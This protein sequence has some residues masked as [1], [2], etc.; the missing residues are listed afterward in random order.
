MR[1]KLLW[2]VVFMMSFLLVGGLLFAGGSKEKGTAAPKAENQFITIWWAQWAPADYLQKLSEDF[3]AKTGIKVI[4]EQT[5]WS[6]F[7]QKY[8]VAMT[9]H[10]SSYD[11]IIADSQDLGAMATG[12]HFVELTDFVK[13]NNI[14]KDFT[15]SSVASFG[16]Y[17]RNSG[18]YYGIPCEA[19]ALG[20]AYRKDLFERADNK[21]A[22]KAKYGYDL[23]IPK[24][25]DQ[26]LDIAKFF[27]GRKNQTS[28]P[29]KKF[30]GVAVYG[31]NGYD[32]LVMMAEQVMWA[33]GGGLGNYQTHKVQGIV[34]SK[35]SIAGIEYY[36]KLFSYDPPGMGDAFFVKC[37]D[38]YT[39]G[40]VPMVSNFYGFFPALANKATNPYADDTGYFACPPQKGVDG[41]IRQ[42]AALGGQGA[43]IV[44]Y[45]KKKDLAYKWME[46]FIQPD[47]QAKWAKL[48]GNSTMKSVLNSDAFLK[49]A[50]YN[51]SL[52]TT[53]E[54]M[55]DFWN[56]PEYGMLFQS[57]AKTVGNYI[58]RNQGT[59][60]EAL[61]SLADQ[62][63]QIFKDAGYYN[64]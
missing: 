40:I 21:A 32:S 26:I 13:K 16:E 42:S 33:F 8:N 4:L 57:M 15:A 53:L 9:A 28:S 37:N 6:N 24:S 55:Q 56:V 1:K 52:K 62:W 64:K 20:W 41:K 54:I 12:G 58:I 36:K 49:A 39:A 38:A 25:W 3:T 11:I 46:W 7:V 2:L 18:K 60:K 19:D 17:P 45:S 59:A 44:T 51:P 5:P 35:G 61:D 50:P 22:F 23:D 29:S 10:S 63:T 48:G 47:V 30:Y 14:D 34:N 27:Y 43:S 31:D